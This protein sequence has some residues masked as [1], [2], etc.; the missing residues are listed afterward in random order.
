MCTMAQQMPHILLSVRM[1]YNCMHDGT[2]SSCI[3]KLLTPAPPFPDM[4]FSGKVR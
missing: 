2:S 1:C 4:V 3:D